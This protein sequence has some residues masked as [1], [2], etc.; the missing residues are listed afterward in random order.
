LNNHNYVATT[1]AGLEHLLAH[2]L[3]N[4]GAQDIDVHT[5]SVSFTGDIELMYKANYYCRTA[6]RILQELKR[7]EVTGQVSLYEGAKLVNWENFIGLHQTF[8]VDSIANQSAFNNTMFVSLKVKDAIV[9]QFR[10]KTGKRP[11]ID[12]EYPQVRIITHVFK[13]QCVLL[14]D[15]SGTSLHKRGYRINQ[16]IAPIN[17]VLAA[18]LIQLSGWDKK[19]T[20]IDGMTGGGTL[21]IEAALL[22]KNIPAGYFRKEFGFENWLTFDRILWDKIILEATQNIQPLT[23]T[24]L[25]LDYNRLAVKIARE[26]VKEAGLRGEVEILNEDFFTYQPDVSAGIVFLNPPYGDRLETEED[27][28]TFYKSIGNALKQNYQGYNAWIISANLEALKHVGLKPKKKIPIQNGTIDARFN[29]YEL[30]KGSHKDFV[31]E[32]KEV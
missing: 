17:E 27:I 2:E 16:V 10:E 12:K 23:G 18:G 29:Q 9:D 19:S 25:G 11:N 7:F 24:I 1:L 28:T 22:A 30:F 13:D 31:T 4:I 3:L 21:A 8:A 26:N 15:S 14:L 32:K 20:F 5:R 6:L